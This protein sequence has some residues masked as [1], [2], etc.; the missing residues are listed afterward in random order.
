MQLRTQVAFAA[1][2]FAFTGAAAAPAVFAQNRPPAQAGQDHQ[3]HHPDGKTT[4]PPAGAPRMG[5]G[6]MM[7]Q[8][9]MMGGGMMCSDMKQM[10]SMMQDMHAMMMPESG[11]MAS[12]TEARIAKLKADLKIADAQAVP[13]NGF[14]DA[15]RQFA[16]SMDENHRQRAMS[17][18]ALPARLAAAEKAM[19]GNLKSMKALEDALKPLYAALSDEQ[20]KIADGLKFGS[21]GLM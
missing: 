8:D 6:G 5:G 13:W 3:A 11:M 16:K 9:G 15:L 19:E 18:D 12:R 4:A 7:G 10:M 21:M 20:K 1:L 2:A 14:A 17:G